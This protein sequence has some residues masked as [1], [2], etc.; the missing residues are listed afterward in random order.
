MHERLVLWIRLKVLRKLHFSLKLYSMDINTLR[1]QQ[2][3]FEKLLSFVNSCEVIHQSPSCRWWWW[4]WWCFEIMNFC[5]FNLFFFLHSNDIL[6]VSVYIHKCWNLI[7][8]KSNQCGLIC[9][10]IELFF[11]FLNTNQRNSEKHDKNFLAVGVSWHS[12]IMKSNYE[13]FLCLLRKCK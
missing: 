13:L 2:V 12:A 4:W 7:K 3:I 1:R 8:S 11:E 10:Y 5:C 9:A 6:F